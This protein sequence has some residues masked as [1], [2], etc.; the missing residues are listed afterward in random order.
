MK[1]IIYIKIKKRL[2]MKLGVEKKIIRKRRKIK[3]N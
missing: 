3:R 2:V 1:S